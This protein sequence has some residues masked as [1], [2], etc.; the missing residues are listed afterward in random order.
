M[1][2]VYNDNLRNLVERAGLIE[3]SLQRGHHW[4]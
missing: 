4:P 1:I 2:L 3:Q